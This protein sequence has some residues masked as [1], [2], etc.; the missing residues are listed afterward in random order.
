MSR[1]RIDETRF[2]TRSTFVFGTRGGPGGVSLACD[3]ACVAERVLESIPGAHRA[4]CA[5]RSRAGRL[6]HCTGALRA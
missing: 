1:A 6:M 2:Q 3:G 4:L 5:I